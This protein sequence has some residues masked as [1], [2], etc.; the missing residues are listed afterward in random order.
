M[1][2]KAFLIKLQITNQY[3]QSISNDKYQDEKIVATSEIKP[4][5]FYSYSLQVSITGGASFEISLLC[6][7]GAHTKHV[8]QNINFS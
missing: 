7:V 6:N 1:T 4:V 8:K 5:N 3:L 2:C